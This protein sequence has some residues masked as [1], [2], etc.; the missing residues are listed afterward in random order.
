VQKYWPEFGGNTLSAGTAAV[1]GAGAVK[2]LDMPED[3]VMP[4]SGSAQP[5]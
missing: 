3:S 5:R 1:H 2:I 4:P